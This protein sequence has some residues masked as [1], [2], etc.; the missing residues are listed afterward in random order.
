MQP[1]LIGL[2][3]YAR[4]GKDTAAEAL[5]EL[6]YERRAFADKLKDL[7]AY[8]NPIVEADAFESCDCCGLQV[9]FER[10]NDH[11]RFGW[12]GA[13]NTYEIR[14]LLQRL[15]VGAREILGDTVWVDA[16]LDDLPDST[17]RV[18]VTD[19]RFPNEADAIRAIGGKV[20]RVERDGVGPVN[21][22]VSETALDLYAFDGVIP[23]DG[24]VEDL[25]KLMR[26]LASVGAGV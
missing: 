3:G 11:L 16:A 12:E 26:R 25:H 10:V 15:G 5:I 17:K 19:V 14:E 1:T 9:E 22:H 20:Y 7:L 8:L 21:G 2:A 4:S 23:N 13:K 18:V 6:G 24:T